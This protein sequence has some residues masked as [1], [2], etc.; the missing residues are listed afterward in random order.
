M[1]F[2]SSLLLLLLHVNYY[3]YYMFS[4]YYYSIKRYHDYFQMCSFPLII[5]N[6]GYS[7]YYMKIHN[8]IIPYLI[9]SSPI[10]PIVPDRNGHWGTWMSW[11][12]CSVSCGSGGNR[13][14]YRK[15]DAP[16]TQ[17]AGRP[18]PGLDVDTGLCN[19]QQCPR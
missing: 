13:K 15:C 2:V 4:Y 10:F 14:R 18:C 19:T 7:T 5:L 17:G 12:S 9:T 3:Y 1:K 16:S 6:V 11:Q 8:S